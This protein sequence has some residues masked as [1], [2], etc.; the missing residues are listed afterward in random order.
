MLTVIGVLLVLLLFVQDWG[1]RSGEP[2]YNVW[3]SV[4]FAI[5][6]VIGGAWFVWAR[7]ANR[8]R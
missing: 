7:A 5:F 2:G 6:G 1:F 4:F 3:G 8:K